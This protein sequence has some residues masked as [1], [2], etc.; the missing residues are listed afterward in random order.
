MSPCAK[1]SLA[2]IPGWIFSDSALALSMSLPLSG[3]IDVHGGLMMGHHG[4]DTSVGCSSSSAVA[5][6][7]CACVDKECVF[8]PCS[9]QLLLAVSNGSFSNAL[10]HLL[11]RTL[12]SRFSACQ[13]I[14]CS[15]VMIVLV[16]TQV[17][18]AIDFASHSF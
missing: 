17:I 14:L 18:E 15:F 11:S 12:A 3:R 6:A 4:S 10:V 1:H 5:G 8:D 2:E 16:R 13:V 7:L 9:W